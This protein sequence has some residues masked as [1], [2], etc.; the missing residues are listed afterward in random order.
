MAE[1]VALSAKPW[2]QTPVPSKNTYV[3]IFLYIHNEI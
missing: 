3:Y 1:G 2:V